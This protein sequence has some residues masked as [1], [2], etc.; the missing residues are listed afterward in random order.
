MAITSAEIHTRNPHQQQRDVLH[1]TDHLGVVEE[2]H[3][4]HHQRDDRREN[5]QDVK[6]LAPVQFLDHHACNGEDG[7][8]AQPPQV[9][10]GH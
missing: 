5:E 3:R 2:A 10:F 7:V 9:A 1:V 6:V 4:P 8:H